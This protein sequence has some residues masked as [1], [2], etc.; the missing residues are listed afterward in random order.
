MHAGRT[1]DRGSIEV[2]QGEHVIRAQAV[3]VRGSSM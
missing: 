1:A 2:K 3:A